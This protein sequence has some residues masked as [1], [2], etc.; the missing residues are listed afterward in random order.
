MFKNAGSK[1]KSLARIIFALNVII[2]IVVGI[3]MI[4]TSFVLL[5]VSV[6]V[7]VL[8]GWLNSIMLYAFGELCENVHEINKKL[9]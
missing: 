3:V 8:I 9:P 6:A 1:L 5:I 4:K 7:G 2:G